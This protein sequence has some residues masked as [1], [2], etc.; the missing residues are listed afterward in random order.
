[1][2]P[3]KWWRKIAVIEVIWATLLYEFL[4]RCNANPLP[5][6][7]LDC[8]AGGSEPPLSL[9]YQYGY[10]TYGIEI[11]ETALA[12]ARRFCAENSMA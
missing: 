10:K 8:G 1:L 5:R 7:V 3:G 6:E 4:R 9:F 12:E 11:A 2:F